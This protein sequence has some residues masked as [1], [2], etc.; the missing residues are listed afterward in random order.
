MTKLQA[1]LHGMAELEAIFFQPRA[2][3]FWRRL[4]LRSFGV[5]FGKQISVARHLY[6]EYAGNIVL[7]DRVALGHHV[8]LINHAP[9]EIGDD[10]VGSNELMINS[11]T[12]DPIT[13]MPKS[14]PVKIGDRVWI[15]TR[16][17]ILDGVTIGDDVVIGAGSL[18]TQDIPSHSVA[19][20]VPARVTGALDRSHVDEL[21][22]W[23]EPGRIR[24]L[25]E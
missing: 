6:I 24:I 23:A 18:V 19:V 4:E 2:R 10:F 9:I 17:T 25:R 3:L 11:G 16:V 14:A 15:G 8:T 22:T 20:G 12:H 21:W 1:F 7:G 13:M 5:R